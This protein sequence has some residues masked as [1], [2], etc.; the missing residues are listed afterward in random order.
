VRDLGDI[1]QRG[2]LAGLGVDRGDLVGG[3]GRHQEVA[4]G[5]IPAAV[6]QELGGPMVVVFR[7]SISV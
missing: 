3:V 7:F 5:S 2:Q 6:M 4:L 1:D